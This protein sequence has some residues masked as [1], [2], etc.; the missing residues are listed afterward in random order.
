[1]KIYLLQGRK[2]WLTEDKAPAEAILLSKPEKVAPVKAE[3][4]E[5]EPEL[6]AKPTPANKAKKAPANKSRKAGSTK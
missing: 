5:E 2:V 3:A 4:K 6:K 1:M